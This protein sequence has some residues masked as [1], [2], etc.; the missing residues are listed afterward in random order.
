MSVDCFQDDPF[1]DVQPDMHWNCCYCCQNY[2][3]AAFSDHI[4]EY[5]DVLEFI[6]MNPL[7][8]D[9]PTTY[10]QYITG[11]KCICQLTLNNAAIK[12]F[13]KDN[14]N[15][16]PDP[17]QN[18]STATSTTVEKS[19]INSSGKIEKKIQHVCN[20]CDRKFVHAS[21]L[22]RHLSKHSAEKATAIVNEITPKKNNAYEV[23][24]E[25]KFC[26]IVFP[27][28]IL[29]RNHLF[30]DHINH[31]NE[32]ELGDVSDTEYDTLQS[33]FLTVIIHQ[34]K[35]ISFFFNTLTY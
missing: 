35:L 27:N 12:T 1:I 28:G 10:S 3:N 24:I 22:A 33:K 17:E 29:A 19:I 25:C 14:L 2:C 11:D 8:N 23:L 4:C 13:L 16:T 18:K 20:I 7:E 15:Y 5:Q 30:K 6:M 32:D 21:G 31:Q 9:I 34:S 26:G